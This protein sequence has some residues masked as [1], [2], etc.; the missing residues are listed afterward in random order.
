MIST[1][2][3]EDARL[4]WNYHRMHHDL[5]PCS[6]AVGLG[7]HD[8]GVAD[9]TA[10]LYHQGMAPVIVF[11]GAT[12]PTTRA[13][14][15][16]GEAVQ[17]R[18]RVLEL[19]VPDSA[20][21]LEPRATNTGENIEFTKAVLADA[22]VEVTSV[23]LVSKPYEERRS[24]AMMRKLWAE[25][26]VV[27]AS[28]PMELKEYADSIGDARMVIDMIVGALQRVL[29]FPGW[30]LAIEQA[31]PDTVVAAYERLCTEGFTSRL[32]SGEVASRPNV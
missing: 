18:E 6:V 23:L 3:W 27:C 8:L 15:P 31:V 20:V 25:V 14:M 9:V 30:D 24:Y 17:Y 5:R 13:R 22:G 2:T 32:L 19:G 11:T 4:L 7:S 10:E 26:D 16:R 1:Q 21:I 12:S 28:T 29:V